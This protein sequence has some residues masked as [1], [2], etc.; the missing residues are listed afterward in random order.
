MTLRKIINDPADLVDEVMDG[1]LAAHGGEIR[2]LTTDRRSLGRVDAPQPG[3]VAIVTGGGSGHL[4]FFLGYVGRG[5]CSAVAVGN[6]FSSPSAA[7]VHAAAASVA[8]E[9]G[10]LLLY[11]NYGGD[12]YNFDLAADLLRAQGTPVRTVL[13]TD[14]IASAPPE[15]SGDRRGVAGLVLVY[16]AA[17][18]A[19][20]ALM[21]LDEVARIAQKAVDRTRTMGVGLAPTILPAAGEPT[22]E[23]GEGEMEI[24]VGIHGER[25]VHR[26]PLETADEITDRF[27]EEIA[28]E[29]DLTEGSRAAVL[30]NGLGATPLEELYVVYRRLAERL[31]A[32]GVDIAHRFV[33]E[34]VTSLE[35]AGVS[36]SV[37]LLDEELEDLIAAP[38]AS[39]FYRDGSS[40]EA[41]RG[42]LR[43]ASGTSVEIRTAEDPGPLRALL[44]GALPQMPAH[45]E[46]LRR[47]DAAVGD[48]DL[49][50]TVSA[51]A[52]AVAAAVAGLPSDAAESVVLLTAASAFASAN[53]STFA[54]LVG[55][56][57]A[58]AAEA[59]DAEAG[60]D[61]A[62]RCAAGLRA[63]A[64]RVSERGGARL[65]DKTFLDVLIPL[66]ELAGAGAGLRA[67]ESEAQRLLAES[68]PLQNRRGRAAWQGERT[69][70]LPDPGSVAVVRFL[71]ALAEAGEAGSPA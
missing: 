41:V 58:A 19:A 71:T 6:V 67:L 11:G 25:G 7:L 13:G 3:R 64:D 48:G 49:G 14:D 70:G 59:V 5:L 63:F 51:G 27:L 43:D 65:G 24:G 23:L 42:E 45:A 66:A 52:E 35:M 29:L 21:P 54:A 60:S 55:T 56:G 9:A 68:T 1:I 8:S 16:K 47:L 10:V 12:V 69:R 22:F 18:A 15:R 46:E 20:E 57:L 31:A 38:A 34:Y 28:G 30:V 50:I 61:P 37:M 4:P 39:P 44:L 17:G 26:G 53:P 2:A 36:V 32:R 33:G 40:D 62:A